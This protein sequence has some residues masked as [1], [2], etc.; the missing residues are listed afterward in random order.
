MIPAAHAWHRLS[1]HG[2]TITAS[3]DGEQVTSVTSS[4]WANGPA[5]L[6]AGAFT[7][8]WPQ[9]QYSNLTITQ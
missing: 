6:E 3:V 2:S 5:G 8:D 9:A 7:Q 1:L 4:T